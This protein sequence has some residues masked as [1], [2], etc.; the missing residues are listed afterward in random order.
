MQE[1]LIIYSGFTF[2]LSIIL[3]VFA[4]EVRTFAPIN[5]RFPVKITRELTRMSSFR[6]WMKQNPS[7]GK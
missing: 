1:I 4:S 6:C 3:S 2:S 5:I 7:A